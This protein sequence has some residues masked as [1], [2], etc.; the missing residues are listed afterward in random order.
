LEFIFACP[1]HQL[2]TTKQLLCKEQYI[3]KLGPTTNSQFTQ[4]PTITC[5]QIVPHKEKSSKL[6]RTTL[7]IQSFDGKSSSF[8]SI[9]PPIIV[10]FA[11]SFGWLPVIDAEFARCGIPFQELIQASSAF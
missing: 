2:P 11:S 7:P 9:T 3:E 8:T 1:P 6:A 10:L 5:N 4:F